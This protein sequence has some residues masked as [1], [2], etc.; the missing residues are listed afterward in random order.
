[1]TLLFMSLTQSCRT[2]YV[3]SI[4]QAFEHMSAISVNARLNLVVCSSF[5]CMLLSSLVDSSFILLATFFVHQGFT[6]DFGRCKTILVW[7]NT[8]SM[9]QHCIPSLASSCRCN[10]NFLSR[11]PHL[12]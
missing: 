2:A 12:R 5:P 1:M 3:F 4:L 8:L 10:C 11:H 7:S 9:W 6:K